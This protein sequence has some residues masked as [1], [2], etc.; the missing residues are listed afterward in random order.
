[1]TK[2]LYLS[3]ATL[4]FLSLLV[5]AQSGDRPT[6]NVVHTSAQIEI[7]GSPNEPAWKEAQLIEYFV[8]NFTGE[9]RAPETEARVLYDDRFLYFAFECKDDNLW[10]TF[11]NRDEHLWT[12][13]VVEVFL[14][15]DPNH[16]NYI[17]LE[18]NPLNTMLDIYLLDIRKPLKYESWNSA[19][20]KWAV[21]L[22]G[23]VD[24]KPGDRGWSCEI[25]LPFDDVVTAPNIPPRPGDRWRMNLYRVEE[26]P[27]PQSLTWA[28]TLQR[29]FHVPS[30][31]GD[32]IFEKKGN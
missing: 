21:A 9:R 25:A 6:Y 2:K 19:D 1:M 7:D 30:K 4:F 11:R 23:N 20:L 26:K 28:P 14:Q 22:D 3:I 31:F 24:G 32:I 15:A 16:P 8:D 10:A 13:E 12:E 17:E 18:V 27:E 29:D 5:V